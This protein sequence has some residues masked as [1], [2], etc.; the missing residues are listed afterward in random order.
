M[1]E[2]FGDL[3]G[4]SRSGALLNAVTR[5]ESRDACSAIVQ[6]GRRSLFAQQLQ[7]EADSVG[8]SRSCE[9]SRW[10]WLPLPSDGQLA[11]WRSRVF[12]F[13]LTGFLDRLPTALVARASHEH[14][15]QAH[16]KN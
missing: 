10:V 15:H 7:I 9:T 12:P 5:T 14:R 13:R 2:D 11:E 4:A 3:S 8:P 1:H 6:R 16:Q